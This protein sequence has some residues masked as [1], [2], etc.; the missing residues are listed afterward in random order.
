MSL[1]LI[2]AKSNRHY[3]LAEKFL[4]TD[5]FYYCSLMEKILQRSNFV[6]LICKISYFNK[7]KSVEGIFSYT[8]N[9]FFT[10]YTTN[11]SEEIKTSLKDFFKLN[12]ICSF[13]GPKK[14]VDSLIELYKETSNKIPDDC[15]YMNLMLHSDLKSN[16]DNS[17]IFIANKSDGNNLFPLQLEYI[18]EEVLTDW[19]KP[20][21]AL[22]R[23]NLDYMI[24]AKKVFFLKEENTII[25]KAHINAET[26]NYCQL[27]GVFTIPSHRN[28]GFATK[29][30]KYLVNIIHQKNKKT[31]LYVKTNNKNAIS[32]YKKAGFSFLGEYAI[33]YY[34]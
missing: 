16:Y 32:A 3:L 2:K 31:V 10:F 4:K 12:K 19:I 20:N 28:K 6:F 30:I 22:E 33:V 29:L 21:L 5:E 14:I 18:K 15:R 9:G 1:K 13:I 24:Q 27:G 17:N 34:K 26:K 11:L 23:H 25:S 8:K 7:I